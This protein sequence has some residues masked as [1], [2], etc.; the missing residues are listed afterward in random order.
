MDKIKDA[1]KAELLQLVG[2]AEK[3]VAGRYSLSA[4]MVKDTAGTTI[5]PDMV[6]TVIGARKGY[7]MCKVS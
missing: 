3:V 5:T 6:G 4:G 2:D 7:R 1:K